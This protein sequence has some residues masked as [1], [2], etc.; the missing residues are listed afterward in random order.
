MNIF[1]AF[2]VSNTGSFEK[3]HFGD[4][5]KFLIYEEKNDELVYVNELVNIFKNFESDSDK[6]GSKEKATKIIKLLK[7]QNV[8]ALVSAQFGRNISVI[9][10]HFIPIIVSKEK[11]EEIVEILQKHIYWIKDELENN[12]S[13]YKLF[14]VK[15]GILKRSIKK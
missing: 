15:S 4:A 1:F 9:N 7:E 3:K 6:H 8:Q 14:S 5:D 12:N 13:D 2:A 11:P 10:E